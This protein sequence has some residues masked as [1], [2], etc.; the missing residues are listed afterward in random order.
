[1][2]ALDKAISLVGG[3]SSLAKRLGVTPNVVSNWRT[4]GVPPE[5]C[6]PIEKA[7]ERQVRCEQLNNKVDWAYLRA[8]SQTA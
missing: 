1:M 7:T 8:A 3:T 4:R 2:N 5:Y 6:P